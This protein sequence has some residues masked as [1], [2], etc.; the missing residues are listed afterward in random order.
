MIREIAEADY[1]WK[2]E[3]CF[4]L[5]LPIWKDGLAPADDS[6][7]REVL[8]LIRWSEPE[9]PEWSPGGYGERGHWMRL[10]ACEALVRLALRFPASSGGQADILAQLTASAVALGQPAASAAAGVL[11]WRF[12][13]LPPEDEDRAFLAFAI[14]L[15]AAYLERPRAWLTEL[16]A[17]VEDEEA[18]ARNE[19][20]LKPELAWLLGLSPFRLRDAVWR[21]LARQILIPGDEP[22]RLLGELVATE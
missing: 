3:K 22:L 10:F 8:E 6:H 9:D 5:L 20:A 13:A 16:A 1:G 18:R 2:A 17:W 14:L 7:L 19:A 4:Q 12:V 15:L 21:S 11:A